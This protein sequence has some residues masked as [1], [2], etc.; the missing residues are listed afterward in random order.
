[1]NE[2]WAVLETVG[3]EA[4]ARLIIGFLQSVDITC[5]LESLRFTQE[6]VNF[7]RLSEIRLLVRRS[8]LQRARDLLAE[9]RGSDAWLEETDEEA[10]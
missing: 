1:M 2:E 9:L 3:V 6:P 7:G 5:Q 8:E 10:P 4:E